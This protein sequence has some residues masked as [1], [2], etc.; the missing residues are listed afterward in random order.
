MSRV[1]SCDGPNCPRGPVSV[2]AA[3]LDLAMPWQLKTPHTWAA[4]YEFCSS[5][6]LIEW[7][8]ESDPDYK[9]VLA[10]AQ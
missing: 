4:G 9:A 7:L 6:C 2:P 10:G 5:G 3:C 8:L 1:V